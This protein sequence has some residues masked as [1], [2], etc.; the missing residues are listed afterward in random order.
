MLADLAFDQEFTEKQL[1]D[2]FGALWSPDILN[3]NEIGVNLQNGERS[4]FRKTNG[5]E[6]TNKERRTIPGGGYADKGEGESAS[7]P[8][9][10]TIPRQQDTAHQQA[11]QTKED[12]SPIVEDDPKVDH[13][14]GVLD[15]VIESKEDMKTQQQPSALL[16]HEEKPVP[17][18]NE[19]EN[20]GSGAGAVVEDLI[21]QDQP[22]KL[23]DEQP[24]LDLNN[25]NGKKPTI[26]QSLP[27]EQE[28]TKPKIENP[29]DGSSS[30]T[31]KKTTS[32]VQ[33]VMDPEIKDWSEKTSKST[34]GIDTSILHK[35][36]DGNSETE[37]LKSKMDMVEP[38]GLSSSASN[39]N[40]A[41]QPISKDKDDTIVSSIPVPSIPDMQPKAKTWAQIAA[42]KADDHDGQQ[43]TL[44]TNPK[45]QNKPN[46]SLS[47]TSV[48]KP[49]DLASS[50]PP[51][52]EI[53]TLV[54]DPADEGCKNL[55]NPLSSGLSTPNY[56]STLDPQECE[57]TKTKEDDN[58][59]GRDNHDNQISS[60]L[61]TPNNV[62]IPDP[63][64]FEITKSKDDPNQENHVGESQAA[65]DEPCVPISTAE[66]TSKMEQSIDIAS[67]KP[68]SEPE[69]STLKGSE[70]E[71][72]QDKD[73]SVPLLSDVT[74]PAGEPC[75]NEEQQLKFCKHFP[76]E[77]STPSS[78]LQESPPPFQVPIDLT[79]KDYEKEITSGGKEENP[80]A[81]PVSSEDRK[82][83]VSKSSE[84]K[85]DYQQ[86][87]QEQPMQVDQ[88]SVPNSFEYKQVV[89]P[90]E[91]KRTEGPGIATEQGRARRASID[92]EEDLNGIIRNTQIQTQPEVTSTEPD[93]FKEG[94]RVVGSLGNFGTVAVSFGSKDYGVDFDDGTK[95]R[96]NED[97]LH[98]LPTHLEF[99]LGSVVTYEGKN[100]IDLEGTVEKYFGDNVY[101]IKFKDG[102]KFRVKERH[103]RHQVLQD[104]E[105]FKELEIT[106][107]TDI[108]TWNYHNVLA[109]LDRIGLR[110]YRKN[111]QEDR[112]TGR[113][114]LT[115]TT[116]NLADIGV[117]RKDRPVVLK[118]LEKLRDLC[119]SSSIP[120]SQ[121]V[122]LE[123]NERPF[124]FVIESY[125]HTLTVAEI[126]RK[127][128]EFGVCRG[129]K[130]ISCNGTTFRKQPVEEMQETIKTAIL[131]ATIKFEKILVRED[132]K[133][134]AP[135]ANKLPLHFGE[136]PTYIIKQGW[137]SFAS[138]EVK[139]KEPSWKKRWCVLQSD[140][141]LHLY[142][143]PTARKS[144]QFLPLNLSNM[145]TRG[146]PGLGK[147]YFVFVVPCNERTY[148]FKCEC[149]ATL[150]G[151]ITAMNE[152]FTAQKK[153]ARKAPLPQGP[154][155]IIE[156]L[157][158]KNE[159][160]ALWKHPQNGKTA[161]Q[162]CLD[163]NKMDI[164]LRYINNDL[165]LLRL[166]KEEGG[167]NLHVL[168]GQA[169][170][171]VMTMGDRKDEDVKQY[172]DT[173]TLIGTI[174]DRTPL[175]SWH[176]QL[177]PPCTVLD[178]L[179]ELLHNGT[180]RSQEDEPQLHRK[181]VLS[182][183]A[184]IA[185]LCQPGVLRPRD[186]L[187][188]AILRCFENQTIS[189]LFEILLK[190]ECSLSLPGTS[191]LLYRA[192]DINPNDVT[193]IRY[194]QMFEMLVRK[195]APV[196]Q[197]SYG[198]QADVQS[199]GIDAL[200]KSISLLHIESIQIMLRLGAEIRPVHTKALFTLV[201]RPDVVIIDKQK[202]LETLETLLSYGAALGSS[203]WMNMGSFIKANGEDLKKVGERASLSSQE[204]IRKIRNCLDKYLGTDEKILNAV[205]QFIPQFDRARF[206]DFLGQFLAIRRKCLEKRFPEK[207]IVEEVRK[208]DDKCVVQ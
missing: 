109:W 120:G 16:K 4:Y 31:E 40:L 99:P 118:E 184:V 45:S 75:E 64:D 180:R 57:N 201:T 37:P 113:K 146:D 77:D 35:K 66:K 24:L 49:N 68:I 129:M 143:K 169:L 127:L 12:L 171:S 133:R 91:V 28:L 130:I 73:P 156:T 108:S 206:F 60:D 54:T 124:D 119:V 78:A 23:T 22:E 186:N 21:T 161:L 82:E 110:K 10:D 176:D 32:N 139:G 27:I 196:S 187:H 122:I 162:L 84:V 30:K 142:T 15:V 65:S 59:E 13:N 6:K 207:R 105:S 94:D 189:H 144:R 61:A 140:D 131:P 102:R 51:V 117:K 103:L 149:L 36:S 154:S 100:N 14:T 188:H 80:G 47:K 67:S 208:K 44:L 41:V 92:L 74:S 182:C 159:L 175:S 39:H 87:V 106:E 199:V 163:M 126:S 157:I 198:D 7:A 104:E 11:A 205:T 90:E 164:I 191:S 202:F 193:L 46:E 26:K 155:R 197:L 72:A 96:V 204:R 170:E 134:P 29:Q 125:D 136:D 121:G 181:I 2:H 69:L 166:S 86:P 172:E 8:E 190:T 97:K 200:T 195:G 95:Y 177:P 101:G 1:Q 76:A 114:L 135:R 20:I 42:T 185:T 53:S 116:H 52:C 18:A 165:S 192:I 168:V 71:A 56:I 19:D 107:F 123:F 63:S 50:N 128:E 147:E 153:R 93:K 58:N 81:S 152:M 3:S 112:V 148:K 141:T 132:K 138:R 89:E 85:R 70:C 194:N 203:E 34:H 9:E 174:Y 25:T 151:W 83:D 173:L 115:L 55:D 183:E 150:N 17:P 111:F 160:S 62:S 179:V 38:E 158:K 5:S 145:S 98:S 79:G 167:L 33:N 43:K 137:L 178:N 48:Q 88:P